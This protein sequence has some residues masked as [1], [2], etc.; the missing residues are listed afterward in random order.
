MIG[1]LVKMGQYQIVWR[2]L[3]CMMSRLWPKVKA[4]TPLKNVQKLISDFQM[5]TSHAHKVYIKFDGRYG[6]LCIIQVVGVNGYSMITI[7]TDFGSMHF[8]I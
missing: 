1:R 8:F 4:K 7:V 3:I 2:V 6:N 5:H